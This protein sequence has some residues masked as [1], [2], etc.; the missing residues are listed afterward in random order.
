M[1]FLNGLFVNYL[2][3]FDPLVPG[4]FFYKFNWSI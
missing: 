2:I 4:K 3:L 1:V